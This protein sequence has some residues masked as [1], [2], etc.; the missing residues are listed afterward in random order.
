MKKILLSTIAFASIAYQTTNA[1]AGE[2]LSFTPECETALALSGGPTNIRDGAGVYI[3]GPDGFKLVQEKTNNFICMVPR[4]TGI[5]IAPQC[6]D[7]I[8][9]ASH[10]KIMLDEGRKLR[11]GMSFEQLSK[12]RKDGFS[13]GKYNAPKGP[14]LVY[15]ASNYN[16]RE[17]A[18]GRKI[19]I[20]PHIMYHAP[21]LTAEDIGSDPQNVTNNYGMPFINS[22]GPLGFMIAYIEHET[23]SSDV[24][25]ACSGQLPDPN[26]IMLRPPKRK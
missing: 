14:G 15:M 3:L 1:L 8:S 5:G 24:I 16:Y 2:F 13:S 6:F 7:E 18:E 26:S 17:V 20:A 25:Q 10:V 11:R 21:N 22:V 4:S 12:D 19:Q 9:Q 23:D